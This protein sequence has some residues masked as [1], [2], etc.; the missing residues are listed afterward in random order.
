MGTLLLV[1]GGAGG[2]RAGGGRGVGLDR[3]RDGG[4]GADTVSVPC[5]Y[6]R[7]AAT[8]SE[9][10]GIDRRRGIMA[11]SDADWSGLIDQVTAQ[12][13]EHITAQA[14]DI[15]VQETN[16]SILVEAWSDHASGTTSPA[17]GAVFTPLAEH[18]EEEQIEAQDVDEGMMTLVNEVYETGGGTGVNLVSGSQTVASAQSGTA[19]LAGGATGTASS[20]TSADLGWGN[21][22]GTASI[23][24][25]ESVGWG[26]GSTATAHAAGHIGWDGSNAASVCTSSNGLGGSTAP[27]NP[28][29]ATSP[30]SGT[31]HTPPAGHDEEDQGNGTHAMTPEG[32]SSGGRN[33]RAMVEAVDPPAPAATPSTVLASAAAAINES[34]VAG[35]AGGGS[36]VECQKK[37]DG[38]KLARSGITLLDAEKKLYRRES[39]QF[40]KSWTPGVY[41]GAMNAR[42]LPDGHGV[43]TEGTVDV[44][45]T[46]CNDGPIAGRCYTRVQH[47]QK[48]VLC[49]GCF[50]QLSTTELKAAFRVAD[51]PGSGASLR[52]EY[53]GEW[54]N[55]LP[56]GLGVLSF[57]D[58]KRH[59]GYWDQGKP[60]GFGIETRPD[61]DVYRG[62]WRMGKREG[63]GVR[64]WSDQQRYGGMWRGGKMHGHGVFLWPS[65]LQ[66]SG[67]WSEHKR[68]GFGYE[69]HKNSTA[70]YV[71]HWES[72][73]RHGLGVRTKADGKVWRGHFHEGKRDKTTEVSL[74]TTNWATLEEEVKAINELA[75][76]SD[77][78]AE[79][80][81]VNGSAR[82]YFAKLQS[83]MTSEALESVF[84]DMVN[85]WKISSWDIDIAALLAH[86]K[87]K[88]SANPDLWTRRVAQH[89]GWLLRSAK[90]G[91]GKEV[92]G[93]PR[94]DGVEGDERAAG[95]N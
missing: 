39:Y 31:D 79:A 83:A 19:Y 55:G 48:L 18:E 10:C 24:S 63:F 47:G 65:Q 43:L 68:N 84:M 75:L 11:H 81:A 89:F 9:H 49:P 28:N 72:G 94:G 8:A 61:G 59:E 23:S 17:I 88:R 3:V 14:N 33:N 52:R 50:D 16:A 46:T 32:G 56:C 51:E 69:T 13:M 73:K 78:A 29:T 93:V 77:E 30:M 82:L 40:M 67:Q 35:T 92:P 20:S 34:T 76:N 74:D 64:F 62:E 60:N 90:K 66:Y 21:N 1:G 70:T 6:V 71:G 57:E 7:I 87:S 38:K 4:G 53:N 5:L 26:S 80:V 54:K 41:E 37:G 86:G 95:S 25:S 12:V 36:S 22:S 58:G 44:V 27:S 85:L 45:C 42:G 2:G 91:R 15:N